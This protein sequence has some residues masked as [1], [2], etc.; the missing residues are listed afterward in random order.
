MDNQD[1]KRNATRQSYRGY[2]TLSSETD[3]YEA[4]LLNISLKGALVA[5]ITPHTLTTDT[6]VTLEVELDSGEHVKMEGAVAHTK[7]H[8]IGVRCQTCSQQ[9]QEQLE[10]FLAKNN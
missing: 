3:S 4:H 9:D 8:F 7:E 2:G 1:N 5:V 6:E 10:R